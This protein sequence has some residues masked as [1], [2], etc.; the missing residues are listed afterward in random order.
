MVAPGAAAA[1]AA[2]DG[3]APLPCS[4]SPCRLTLFEGGVSDP[5]SVDSGLGISAHPLT[6][7]ASTMHA[8]A[9]GTAPAK[10]EH[11][12]TEAATRTGIAGL[13]YHRVSSTMSSGF[14]G[15]QD[16]DE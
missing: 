11:N 1:A 8:R 3:D 7:Y 2:E 10:H 13:L 6:E 9:T 12:Q 4:P 5:V 15:P 16:V 14:F